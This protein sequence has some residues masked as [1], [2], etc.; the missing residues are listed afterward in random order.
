MTS[1]IIPFRRIPHQ[2]ELYLDYLDFSPKVLRFY[3][4]TPVL[5]SVESLARSTLGDYPRREMA[6]I[7]DSQNRA[8]GSAE[9]TFDHI[10]DLEQ[11]DSVAVDL[12]VSGTA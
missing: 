9:R 10:R 8:F 12:P 7:L 1:T 5:E 6:E 11:P 2:S 4:R 3:A